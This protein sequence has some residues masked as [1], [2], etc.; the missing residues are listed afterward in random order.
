MHLGEAWQSFFVSPRT[1]AVQIRG[2]FARHI[3]ASRE[4]EIR[5]QCELLIIDHHSILSR[6]GFVAK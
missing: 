1:S 5:C 6:R 4:L 3:A 2:L